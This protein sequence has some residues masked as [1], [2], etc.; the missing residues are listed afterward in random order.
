[1]PNQ[2][3]ALAPALL[4]L[5]FAAPALATEAEGYLYGM[6]V[7]GNLF[8]IDLA[9]GVGELVGQLPF[10]PPE[11]GEPRGGLV[12]YNEFEF[13]NDNLLAWA[14]Q[15][16]GNFAAQQFDINSAAGIGLP[17]PNAA[18]WHGMEYIGGTLYAAGFAGP[19]EGASLTTLDPDTGV[20]DLIGSFGDEIGPMTGL[21]FDGEILYGIGNSPGGGDPR[22]G[23]QGAPS[24]LYEIEMDTGEAF[25]IGSTGIK[26]GSLEF[27]PNGV[28]YAGGSG[29]N[30][31]DLY[32]I[33]PLDASSTF[34]G[35]TGFGIPEIRGGP[36]PGGN[37]ISGLA[38]VIPTP[39]S[40]P[41][42]ALGALAASRRRR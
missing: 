6:D 25:P 12:G 33:N 37:G 7:P 10:I 16:D 18:S 28:L 9:T 2:T 29:P 35:A 1:M 40:V 39:A 13:D 19:F 11:G 17:V 41:L 21:A 20:F 8:R 5:A 15:R 14:Q 34:I 38:L 27:G 32:S 24:I 42:L 30:A 22:G 3:R 4:S 31:G 26:A 36:E 23:N